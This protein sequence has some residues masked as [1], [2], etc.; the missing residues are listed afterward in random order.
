M[1]KFVESTN[2]YLIKNFKIY[3]K[4]TKLFR[5]SNQEFIFLNN[6]LKNIYKTDR[7]F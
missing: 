5:I 4:K 6:C 7:E 2:F 3:L 1:I